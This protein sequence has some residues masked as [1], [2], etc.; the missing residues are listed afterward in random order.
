MS[1]D[2]RPPPDKDSPS[3]RNLR[4]IGA[5]P[6]SVLEEPRLAHPEVHDAVL[7]DEIVFDG[8]DET[9]VRLRMF[10]GIGR[11]D[12][13]SQLGIDIKVALRRPRQPI[14]IVQ[15]GVEPLGTVGGG[16][17][18]GQHVAHLIVEG[19]RIFRRLEVAVIFAPEGP[20]AGQP[21]KHL[22]GIALAP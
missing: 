22:P 9:G 6:G 5:G 2:D 3:P 21:I 8:L 10:E 11:P 15:A 4:E 16:H 13:L 18:V 20:A 17:L 14:G 7:V 19:G 1:P 12:D